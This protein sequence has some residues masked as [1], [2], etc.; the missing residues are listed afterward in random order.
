VRYIASSVYYIILDN[1]SMGL[2]AQSNERECISGYR[3][4]R[5]A[6]GRFGEKGV[7]DEVD[8]A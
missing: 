7:C 4:L 8:Y 2:T 6:A 5:C 1:L 3:F